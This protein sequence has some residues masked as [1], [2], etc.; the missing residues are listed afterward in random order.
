[1]TS[2]CAS[3][4]TSV[5]SVVSTIMRSVTWPA[6]FSSPATRDHR[7]EAQLPSVAQVSATFT[8]RSIQRSAA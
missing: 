5:F 1:M 6:D 7:P 3:T 2:R 8:G 4:A